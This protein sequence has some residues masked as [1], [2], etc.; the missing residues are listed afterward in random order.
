M[1]RPVIMLAVLALVSL[2]IVFALL[3]TA[4]GPSSRSPGPVG[5]RSGRVGGRSGPGGGRSGPGGD[6]SGR[7][8]GSTGPVGGSTGPVSN[9]PNSPTSG[10]APTH[11]SGSGTFTTGIVDTVYDQSQARSTWLNRTV[12]SGAQ[13]ILM[14]VDWAAVSPQQ[15]SAGTDPSD[16]GN[17]AYNWGTLD[18]AVRAAAA[19]GLT[20][21][22][23]ITRVPPWAEGPGQPPSSV[24]DTWRP[25][26]T[27]A[28]AFAKAVARR[29][30]GSFNP[31]TGVLPR[32]RYF[33]AW[34]EPNLPDQISP[35]WIRVGRHWV[36]ESPIIYR[37]LL[38]GIYKAVK[39]VNSSNVVITAGTAPYGDPPGG[40]RMRPALFWQDVL[41]LTGQLK[42]APCPNPAHFDVLAHDPYSFAGPLRRAYWSNDVTLP[43]M[44][45]LTRI[46]AAAER[47]G[48]ALPH[49][50]HQVWV[51]EFGWNSWP[52]TRGGVP[53]R[54]RARWIDEALYELWRQGITTAMWYLIVDQP[55]TTGVSWQTGLY[56]DNG[57]RKPGFEAFRFPFVAEPVAKGVAAVWAVSPHAGTVRVQELESGRWKT[58]LRIRVPAHSV[59]DRTVATVGRPMFRAVAGSDVSLGWRA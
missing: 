8:G 4:G 30:S 49:V 25:N 57:R 27:A 14:W 26:A 29:Y 35:Q 46:L 7:V 56:Y 39:A 11:G 21:V 34:T 58:A 48:R 52:P 32:V 42:P 22:L 37:A 16:P 13:T 59:I 10:S 17:P 36:A 15:P 44:W 40:Q 41:C 31:G 6:S 20:V 12:A 5:G 24:P 43:D 2:T 1:R 23:S 55:R 45:K 51:T 9:K 33:Q 54:T 19:H 3:G 53:I 38:N 47:T 28:A 50:N 18:A